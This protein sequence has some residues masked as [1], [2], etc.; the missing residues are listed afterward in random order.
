MITLPSMY[1]IKQL[2]VFTARLTS[3]LKSFFL[4]GSRPVKYFRHTYLNSDSLVFDGTARNRLLH[5][6][7]CKPGIGDLGIEYVQ[8][9]IL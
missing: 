2:Q 1:C 8:K 7:L 5:P 6:F 4:H 9:V 3:Y